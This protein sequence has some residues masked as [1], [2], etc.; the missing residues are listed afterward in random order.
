MR[1]RVPIEINSTAKRAKKIA[2]VRISRHMNLVKFYFKTQAYLPKYG[3]YEVSTV[4]I[5]PTT[6]S[7]KVRCTTTVLRA[8]P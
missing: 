5:E 6:L 4:G 3:W 1:M 7:L 2:D 8:Q